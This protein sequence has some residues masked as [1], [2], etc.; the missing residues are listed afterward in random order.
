MDR[1]VEILALNAFD[2]G[3]PGSPATRRRLGHFGAAS[4]LF[5]DDP[6]E[7]VSAS[8]VWVQA[9][10]GRRYLDVYNNVPSVGHSHPRVVAAIQDQVARLNINTRYLNAV[11][12]DYA[13]ALLATMPGALSNLVMTCSGSEANDLALRIA[14]AATGGSGFVVTRAAYHGNT[15]AVSA[16]SPVSRP[17]APLAAHV[18]A[19][20]PPDGSATAGD[21]MAADIAAAAADLARHGIAFA[22]AIFDTAF[23]SDG[24]HTDPVGLLVPVAQTIHALGGLLIAD[25]VQPGFGRTGAGLWGFAR[26]GVTPDIVTLGKPMGNGFPMAGV[27]TRP[28]LLA[29]FCATEKYFNTFGG[30]PVAAAAGRAVLQV[31]AE[32]GLI[33]NA[34]S[35]GDLLRRDLRALNDPRIGAVRGAGL[36]TGVDLIDPATGAPDAALARQLINGLRDHGILIGAAGLHGNA[37]KIRP[38][39][40]FGPDH[41]AMVTQA[42]ASV[43][44]S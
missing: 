4:V 34:R 3:S 21:R 16:I 39:L 37:L 23:S 43:L 12:D 18:R 41:A 27:V 22:G 30:N 15:T 10:D 13:G 38:P 2:P 20:A 24:V 35:T 6:I 7:L 32:E 1:T 9:A 5:Y 14:Q 8:G 19:I 36:F 29:G 17:G 25:E 26:H 33:D 28:D 44:A 11:V 42:L 40:C 31:I